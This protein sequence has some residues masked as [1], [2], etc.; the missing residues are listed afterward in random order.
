MQ[1]GIIKGNVEFVK[2]EKKTSKAGKDYVRVG[3]KL[4]NLDGWVNG[5]GDKVTDGWSQGDEVTV[6]LKSREYEGKTYWD[7]ETLT[8]AD[9]LVP[10][11]DD[12][13]KRIEKIEK[14]LKNQKDVNDKEYN[15][16]GLD[17]VNKPAFEEETDPFDNF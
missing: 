11:M 16:D 15:P 5:F 3:L 10:K 8:I 4:D 12:L 2:S 13:E 17:T 6:R 1:E 14:H 7:F 9:R